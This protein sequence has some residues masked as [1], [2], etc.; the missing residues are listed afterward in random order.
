MHVALG[1]ALLV[2]VR[3]LVLP[4]EPPPL[5]VELVRPAP[6]DVDPRQ[7]A[8]RSLRP[9]PLIPRTLQPRAAVRREASGPF[10]TAPA[11]PPAPGAAPQASPSRAPAVAAAPAAHGDDPAGRVRDALRTSVGCDDDPLIGLSPREQA[12][13]ARERA[14]IARGAPRFGPAPDK[15][16]AWSG[17]PDPDKPKVRP[18]VGVAPPV[19][20]PAIDRGAGVVIG[21]R[22]SIPFGHPPKALPPIP[23]STLYGDD[24]LRKK[25]EPPKP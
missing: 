13:C 19:V 25:P 8:P 14:R 22:A 2:S 1:S 10:P 5:E 15:V 23:P 9:P 4:P 18:F 24:R 7:S 16:R 3:R 21:A 11:A 17:V 20:A 6:R 12:A